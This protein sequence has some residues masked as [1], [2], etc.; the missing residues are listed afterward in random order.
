MG[1]AKRHVKRGLAVFVSERVIRFTETRYEKRI[2]AQ[3][4]QHQRVAEGYDTLRRIMRGREITRIPFTGDPYK[5][6]QL[7]TRATKAENPL[8]H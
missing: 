7:R 4:Q 3:A 5:L 8:W 6:L 1:L 2:F